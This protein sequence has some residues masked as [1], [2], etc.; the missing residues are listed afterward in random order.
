MKDCLLLMLADENR[1]GNTTR[2]ECGSQHRSTD[3]MEW[4]YTSPKRFLQKQASMNRIK[5]TRVLGHGMWALFIG[6]VLTACGGSGGGAQAPGLARFSS[7]EGGCVRDN[8][9]GLMWE[10][11][12][13]DGELHDWNQTFT[14]YDDISSPQKLDSATNILSNPTQDEIDDPTNSIGFKDTVNAVNLCGFNDWRLP[15]LEELQSIVQNGVPSPGPAIDATWFPNTKPSAFWTSSPLLSPPPEPPDPPGL[16]HI[17]YPYYAFGIFFGNGSVVSYYR[18]SNRH[19][20][21]VRTD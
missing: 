18:S 11:K 16:P 6:V 12:T 20:R 1:T 8:V 2:S 15:T 3:H 13:T 4:N 10:V 19:V 9:T 14:N 7:I 5:F 21:L 17:V